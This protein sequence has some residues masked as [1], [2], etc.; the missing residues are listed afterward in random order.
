MLAE[1]AYEQ[2]EG[3]DEHERR[4]QGARDED[5]DEQLFLL[6]GHEGDPFE[7][8]LLAHDGAVGFVFGADALRLVDDGLHAGVVNVGGDGELFAS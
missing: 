6:F 1:R 4:E 2:V 3:V 7:R 8:K 5:A